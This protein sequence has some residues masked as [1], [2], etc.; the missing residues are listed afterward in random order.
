MMDNSNIDDLTKDILSDSK[1]ELTNSDFENL[2][3]SKI[4]FESRKKVIFQNFRLFLIRFITL[5]AIIFSLS[6]IFGINITDITTGIDVLSTGINTGIQTIFSNYGY[7]I[8]IYFIILSI[9]IILLSKILSTR[10]RY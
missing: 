2:L 4:R 1:L 7:L 10:Y 9:V 8:L 6:K 5:D 3:M